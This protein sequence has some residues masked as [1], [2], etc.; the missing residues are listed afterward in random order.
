MPI[1]KQTMKK[2][3]D[4]GIVRMTYVDK[5]IIKI[6]APRP[7]KFERE[8]AQLIIKN[9]IAFTDN[10]PHCTLL[11]MENING[12][13]REARQY[14]ADSPDSDVL[15]TAVALLVRNPMHQILGNFF[16]GF[17]KP[18]EFDLRLFTDESRAMLWLREM[19][20]VRNAESPSI[21]EHTA[22][23]PWQETT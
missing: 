3:L 1:R 18:K 6:V 12:A 2:E 7:I 21:V 22:L 5:E 10:K 14:V 20:E 17:N 11:E 15:P 13:S 16:L 4:I 9:I 23:R 8:D 19:I